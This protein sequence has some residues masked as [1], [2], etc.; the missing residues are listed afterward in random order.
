MTDA[1][2]I[3]AADY[4]ELT[5]LEE[6]L[7][8]AATRFDRE[9]LQRHL[10]LDFFEFGRS[11]RS[12]SRDEVLAAPAQPID[13][14]LPLPNLRVRL[15]DRD[16]AQVTYDSEVTTAGVVQHAH[17]SSI[18]SRSDTTWVLRFHQGTPFVP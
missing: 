1:L 18:W 6:G 3:T 16:V 15:L 9:H 4:A 8:R 17:R 11:G 5:R 12:H 7:W 13:A 14:L 2:E 10:A